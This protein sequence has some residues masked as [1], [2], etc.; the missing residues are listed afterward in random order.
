MKIEIK[1]II[2]S[3][4]FEHDCD[5]N[6]IKKTLS[7]AS[8][9]GANLSEADLHEAYLRGADLSEADGVK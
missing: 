8:L 9:S 6:T 7:R 2:G 3:L 5:N 1:S 4:L